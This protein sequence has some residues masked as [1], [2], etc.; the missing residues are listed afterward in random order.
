MDMGSLTRVLT[1]LKFSLTSY[2]KQIDLLANTGWKRILP[3]R[4]Y[5]NFNT[6][7]YIRFFWG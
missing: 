7:K 4:I 1:V 3:L 6:S 5:Y 2:Q